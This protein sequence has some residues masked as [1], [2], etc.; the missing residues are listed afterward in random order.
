M[1]IFWYGRK[2]FGLVTSIGDNCVLVPISGKTKPSVNEVMK[3]N[4]QETAF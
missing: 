2:R 4:H 1:E 3:E